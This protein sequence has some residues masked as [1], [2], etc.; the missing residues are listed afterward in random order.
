MDAGPFAHRATQ[1]RPSVMV[2]CPAN[3]IASMG[4]GGIACH[5]ASPGPRRYHSTGSVWMR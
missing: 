3:S 5:S 2:A 1:S 4:G